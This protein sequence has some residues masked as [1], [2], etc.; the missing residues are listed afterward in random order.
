MLGAVLFGI[1][2]RA[3]WAT[4]KITALPCS[5]TPQRCRPRARHFKRTINNSDLVVFLAGI[6][7]LFLTATTSSFSR[8][9]LLKFEIVSIIR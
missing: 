9:V 7:S 8:M 3:A 1:F 2:T 4:T 6:S 5:A